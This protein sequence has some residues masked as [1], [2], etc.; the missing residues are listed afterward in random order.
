MT[1]YEKGEKAAVGPGTVKDP[2]QVVQDTTRNFPQS[3]NPEPQV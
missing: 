1:C 3:L 2:R